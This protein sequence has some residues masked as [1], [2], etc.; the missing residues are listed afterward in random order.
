MRGT[1]R[2]IGIDL[3]VDFFILPLHVPSKPNELVSQA[4]HFLRR[5]IIVAG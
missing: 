4:L 3:L 1:T 2:L 5:G